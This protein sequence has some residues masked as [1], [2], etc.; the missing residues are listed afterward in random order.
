MPLKHAPGEPRADLNKV[1]FE[2][3]DATTG[4]VISCTVSEEA[5]RKISGG[6]A[7]ITALDAMF[8]NH[9]AAIEAVASRKY[10]AGQQTP[11]LQAADV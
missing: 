11:H 1:V 2:M 4:A 6:G 8:A 10:D 9:R 5:L 3:Q 7:S